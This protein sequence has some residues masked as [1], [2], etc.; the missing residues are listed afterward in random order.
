MNMHAWVILEPLDTVSIRDGRNFAAGTHSTG[1]ASTPSPSTIAGA[2]G[3]AYGA[4]P[5]TVSGPVVVRRL[6]QSW[7]RYFPVPRDVVSDPDDQWRLLGPVESSASGSPVHGA[8][9]H[10]LSADVAEVTLGDGDPLGGWWETNQLQQYLRE[11]ANWSQ[12]LRDLQNFTNGR[13]RW[14]PWTVEGRVGLTRNTERMGVEGYLYET[15]HLRPCRDAAFAAWCTDLPEGAPRKTIRLG[16]EARRAEVSVYSDSDTSSPSWP[17]RPGDFPGGRLLLYL[18]TPAVFSDGWRPDDA[19][20]GYRTEL[21][22]AVVDGPDVITTATVDETT[23]VVKASRLLWAVSAGSVYYL[24]FPTSALAS[25]FA[26]DWHGR[27]LHQAE[28]VYRTA[29]FGL[30]LMGGW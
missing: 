16:G 17:K 3:A 25:A 5:G 8:V 13:D 6:E 2:I 23:A 12:W 18:A 7:R 11:R 21:V 14:L 29:G 9:V 20:R 27:C 22:S 30:A 4:N 15:E 10:D 28:D 24:R 1:R 19:L 26:E